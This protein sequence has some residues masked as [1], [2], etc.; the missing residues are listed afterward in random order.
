MNLNANILKR[1]TMH[2][3]RKS[4]E[5][6][7][8]KGVQ[9]IRFDLVSNVKEV[10]TSLLKILPDTSLPKHIHPGGEE[11]FVVE[12]VFQDERGDYPPGSYIRNPPGSSHY[13][14]TETGGVLFVK[15]WQCESTDRWKVHVRAYHER[16][17]RLKTRPGVELRQLYGDYRED[18]RLEYWQP[19]HR[20]ELQPI[21]GLELFVLDGGFVDTATAFTR[22]SWLR[23]P[24]TENLKVITGKAG[25]KLYVKEGHLVHTVPGRPG[26][27]PPRTIESPRDPPT[28]FR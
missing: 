14:K 10:S 15:L 20:I 6:T 23:I 4:W 28:E 16:P 25:A 7:R 3:N 11:I 27:Q 26:F 18:V 1:A 12:G 17:F 21:N 24:P 8:T 22:Y 19:D 5:K 9:R 13:P 2:A